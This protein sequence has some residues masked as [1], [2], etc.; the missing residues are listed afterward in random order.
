[1]TGGQVLVHAL[2]KHDVEIAFGVAGESYLAVL[3]ALYD[4]NIRFITNRQ[5]GGAAFM[6]E[7]YAKLTGKT[8]ICFV[9]RGP[10]ATNGAIGVH[11]A[12]QDST[13]MIYLIG[14]V[15]RDQEGREA[16]Q[17]I[18]YR[19]MFKPPI[20]KATCQIEHADDV[21]EVMSYAFHVAN[22]GRK[23]PVVISLP[24]DMLRELTDKMAVTK[25]KST[26]NV[27][28]GDF[29]GFKAALESASKPVAILGGSGWNKPSIEGFAEWARAHNLPIVTSFRRQD[30]CDNAH[31]CYV[32]EL[33][34]GPNPALVKAVRDEADLILA[35]NTRIGEIASQGYT[36]LDIP[37]P[38]QKLLHIYPE[39]A[40]L[41]KVYEADV[42][43]HADVNEFMAYLPEIDADY[44]EWCGVLRENYL[45]WTKIDKETGVFDVNMDLIF[46]YIRENSPE[47]TIYT[48]DAG[49]F[50][51]WAQRYLKYSPK[52]RLLAPTSGAMGYGVPSAI[53]ASVTRPDTTVIGMMGDGGFMMSGQELATAMASKAKSIILL[54]NNG[55]YG[56]I[57]M[58]QQRDYPGRTIATDLYNPDFTALA[59][60]YGANAFKVTKT[61]EFYTAFDAALKSDV[62]TVIEVQN[63][64]DQI[65][66]TK[67]MADL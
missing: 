12:K 3:D 38:R 42:A 6:A 18:D 9:T 11:T 40:E 19:D 10:G 32:G 50:S 4:S 29:E 55:I 33:G 5:E 41:G 13:P 15:A 47:D 7:A 56:T 63:S 14:Q 58:H 64:P 31:D 52:H 37:K 67:R 45:N 24:E 48:T 51:G 2:E 27:P 34:T 62:L 36:L 8:G 30:L 46:K 25:H 17:E 60:S 20:A 54:F 21:A 57:R 22:D 59:K 43:I 44:T 65:T 49:N 66:T 26:E 39:I 28:T 16:F 23:G 61:E 1:M 35:V 53:S